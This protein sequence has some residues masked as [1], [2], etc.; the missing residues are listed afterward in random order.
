MNR[1]KAG[2]L[3]FTLALVTAVGLWQSAAAQTPG[4]SGSSDNAALA[5][6]QPPLTRGMVEGVIDFLQWALG[7]ELTPSE[8]AEFTRQ[9]VNDWRRNDRTTVNSVVEILKAR[10]TLA[11]LTAEQ[12]AAARREL[13][14]ALLADLRK[15]PAD[16]TSRLLLAAYERGQNLSARNGAPDAP[17]ARA[18][19]GGAVPAALVGKWHEGRVSTINYVNRHT[20]SYAPPSGNRFEYE[21]RPD[22]TFVLSGLLQ[23]SLYHCTMSVFKYTTG[24]YRVSGST[25]VLE[26]QASKMQ[27]RDNCNKRFNQDKALPLET[28]TYQWAVVAGEYGPRLVLRYPDG[29]QSTFGL[30]KE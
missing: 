26:E 22:G 17:P 27:S 7:A 12:R 16:E 13:Q 30:V 8:R 6:G 20:G 24:T 9:C 23:S 19:A 18:Q 1:T 5:A 10:E 2:L 15:T 21:F 28:K 11:S 4:A 25:L 29:Q 3:S 14:P